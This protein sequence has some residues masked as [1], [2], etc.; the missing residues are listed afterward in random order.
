MQMEIAHSA[1]EA[2]YIA[3]SQSMCDLLLIQQLLP[4]GMLNLE[5]KLGDTKVCSTVFEDNNG[6]IMLDST[7]ARMTPISKHIG[8]KYHFFQEHI[9]RGTMQIQHAATEFQQADIFT[10]GLTVVKFQWLQKS[11]IG[12]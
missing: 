6:V 11:L 5:L 9:S 1:T 10:K 4:E 3:L 12:W 7:P 8:I 2:K